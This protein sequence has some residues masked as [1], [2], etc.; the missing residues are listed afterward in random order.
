MKR[1]VC[2]FTGTRA[3]Y[4]ILHWLM[5]GIQNELDLELQLIVSGTHLSPEFGLTY[6]EIEK[7]GFTIDKKVEMIL[8]ADTP[9]AISKSTGLGMI[10]FAD[11]YNDLK[12]DVVVLLG[13]RYELIAASLSALYCSIPIA[14]IAG[15]ESTIGAFDEAIRH[16]IT[17]MAWWHFTSTE[18]YKNR[19]IQMGENPKRVYAVGALN[20]DNV[21][22]TPLLNKSELE[23]KI[24]FKFGKR[25]LL[26]TFHPVTMENNT[27]EKHFIELL[28]ALKTL[29]HTRFIFT[30][31]N[32]DTDGRVIRDLIES[33]T[34][35]NNDISISFQ[36]MGRMN[37]LS[38]LQFID[39]VVGNSSSGLTEAPSFK[40]GTINIG[41]RQKGRLKAKSI[42]DCEPTTDSIKNAIETLY[43]EDFQ[44]MLLTVVNPMGEGDATEKIM[45][46][47][48]NDSIPK[49]LK[50]E[51]Y[52]L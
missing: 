41:D 7:D 48:K 46:I 24:G 27:A 38:S 5:K 22:K 39:G 51:F 25:N 32:S 37:Y 4:G 3:E 50:K 12:P 44:R 18:V 36:S 13:D 31:P 21:V 11:A 52:D 34:E 9:S 15:G 19:V 29:N 17:K 49:E 30:H 14:H 6:K 23:K 43:S 20:I 33:F 28:N 40:I 1:K 45:A 42:I 26:V 10:G 16:S 2:V 8:S 47:I 35:N